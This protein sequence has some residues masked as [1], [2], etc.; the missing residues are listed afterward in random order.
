MGSITFKESYLGKRY[1]EIYLDGKTPPCHKIPPR[2]STGSEF[3]K[4]VSVKICPLKG[5]SCFPDKFG[6]GHIEP[7]KNS[8]IRLRTFFRSGECELNRVNDN[9]P[10]SE[11]LPGTRVDF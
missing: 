5:I 1:V 11:I 7:G 9:T 8:N 2:Q 6:K 3:D 4:G 10:I